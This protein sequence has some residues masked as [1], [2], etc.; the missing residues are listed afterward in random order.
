MSEGQGTLRLRQ[1][2][3][4]LEADLKRYPETLRGNPPSLVLQTTTVT[5]YPSGGGVFYA[6]Q[7]CQVAGDEV[8]GAAAVVT[9]IGGV[10]YACNL[11]TGTPPPGSFHL[12]DLPGPRWVFRFDDMS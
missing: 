7:R 3:A 6:V 11:G 12:G 1:R 9:A 4:D 5:T 10:F 8:E 2:V